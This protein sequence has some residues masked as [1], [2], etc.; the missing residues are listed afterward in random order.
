MKRTEG[1]YEVTGPNE[2]GRALPSLGAAMSLAATRAQQH[3]EEGTWYV[4]NGGGR[5]V[6]RVDRVEGGVVLTTAVES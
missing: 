1:S 2:S 6:A 4:R 5:P 3:S